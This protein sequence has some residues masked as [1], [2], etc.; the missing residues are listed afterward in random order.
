MRGRRP[1]W[2]PSPRRSPAVE[3]YYAADSLIVDGTGH[4]TDRRRS[5][6]RNLHCPRMARS[7]GERRAGWGDTAIL[8]YDMDESE[9]IHGRR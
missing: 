4:I 2:M 3:K 1:S 8:S 7:A 6:R 5:S 9:T